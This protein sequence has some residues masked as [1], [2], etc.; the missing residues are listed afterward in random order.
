MSQAII[1]I[2]INIISFVLISQLEKYHSVIE[3]R[4]LKEVVIFLYTM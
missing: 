1:T 3:T 4:R 2:I